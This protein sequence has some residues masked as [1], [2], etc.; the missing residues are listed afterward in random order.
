MR[1]FGWVIGKLWKLNSN[2]KN[3]WYSVRL[4]LGCY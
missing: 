2:V 1:P 3:L 4:T